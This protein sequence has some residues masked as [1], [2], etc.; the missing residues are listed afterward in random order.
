MKSTLMFCAA[1]LVLLGSTVITSGNIAPPRVAP[2]P[3]VKGKSIRSNLVVAPDGN[4]WDARLQISRDSLRQLRAALDNLPAEDST[5]GQTSAG[6]STRT[7]M[8]GLFMFLAVSF[9]GVWL[10]RS[11]HGRTQKAVAGLVMAGALVGATAMI[12]RGNAAPPPGLKW[13][14]LSKNLNSG[15]ETRGSVEI[16]IVPDGRGVKLIVPLYGLNAG[17]DKKPGE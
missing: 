15:V 12:T 16:E 3:E 17:A 5:G 8:A 9:A 11:G 7:I 14:E 13:R 6:N 1:F 2:S 4:A 10:A